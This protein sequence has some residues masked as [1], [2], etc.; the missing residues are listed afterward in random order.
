M[1]IDLG[2]VRD[3]SA[4]EALWK[5]DRERTQLDV[6]DSVIYSQGDPSSF[7]FLPAPQGQKDDWPWNLFSGLLN[8]CFRTI[9]EGQDLKH[10]HLNFCIWPWDGVSM[11]EVLCPFLLFVCLFVHIVTHA[12]KTSNSISFSLSQLW[13]QSA[14]ASISFSLSQL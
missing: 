6:N 5:S 4:N 13:S 3:P 8:K 9:P 11:A 1:A 2:W 7:F 12:T 14:S 10:R